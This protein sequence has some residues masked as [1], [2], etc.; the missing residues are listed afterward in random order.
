[1]LMLCQNR[2][3]IADNGT[4]RMHHP[5][6]SS[7]LF[8]K[9]KIARKKNS[10]QSLPSPQSSSVNLQIMDATEFHVMTASVT[11]EMSC[12]KTNFPIDKIRKREPASLQTL[13]TCSFFLVSTNGATSIGF[14]TWLVRVIVKA[15]T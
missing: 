9:Q 6:T 12:K 4:H 8:L 2:R 11:L 14:R 13:V 3:W 7:K 10:S 1:M 15:R 5:I